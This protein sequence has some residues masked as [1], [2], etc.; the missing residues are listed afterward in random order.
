MRCPGC[1]GVFE[2]F[3]LANGGVE[4]RPV[5]DEPVVARSV[6]PPRGAANEEAQ[7]TRRIFT[8][9]RRNRAMGGYEPFGKSRSYLGMLA[10]WLLLG[11]GGFAAYWYFT[12]VDTML[13]AQGRQGGPNA[14]NRDLEVKRKEFQEKRKKALET[15]NKKQAAKGQ[16]AGPKADAGPN[17]EG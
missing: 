11:V 4:L 5:D 1:D 7:R 3:I 10:F 6:L 17:P 15:L 12:Q 8:S 13:A 2:F 14:M 9:R 16:S